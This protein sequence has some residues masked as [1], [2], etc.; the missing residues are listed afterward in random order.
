V[1]ALAVVVAIGVA[2]SAQGVEGHDGSRPARVS[3]SIA[4]GPAG[5]PVARTFI[6]L[7]FEVSSAAQIARYA[8]HGNFARML[9]T[10]GPGLLRL[11]GASADTRV[12]WSD[13]RTPPPAWASSVIGP[14]DLHRLRRLAAETGWRVLLT[15]GL[16]H[17]EPVAAA[18]EA[19]AA[20]R[21]LGSLL[22]GIEVGNEPDSYGHHELRA[23]PWTA[24]VY[25]SEVT[26]YRRAIAHSAPGIP[27]A[28]PGVSG[29][30]AFERWG[31]AEASSQRPALLTGH[32]YPLRCD[33]VP[34][35]SIE[36]L[37]SPRI[38]SLEGVSLARYLQV[39]RA[40][41]TGFRMDEANTVSC[42]GRTGISDTFGSAL[43]AVGY[44]TQSMTAGIS[45]INLQ[46]A[47]ANCT[48][49]SPVCAPT[50]AR[51]AE[52]A[53]QAQPEW[54]A[55]LMTSSLIGDRPLHTRII[56][57]ERPDLATAALRAPDGSLRFVIVEDDPVGTP[58][59]AVRLHVGHGMRAASVLELGA[60]SPA[61]RT[62]IL[63]GGHAVA[64]D[65]S[66]QPPAKLRQIAV[67]GGVVS[68][69]VPASRA[70][71]V[72]VAPRG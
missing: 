9:R 32:H 26:A 15:L 7:S 57:P 36:A 30:K 18:R 68:I 2:L 37:L 50:P 63:L 65:G 62:G 61:A 53:L 17:Y 28:G 12:G 42:G 5:A 33:S 52:G 29:S 70:V 35:P 64:A 54:Y 31:V 45:G 72:T 10:L 51:L 13:S 66:W 58:G 41:H 47:P 55:L 4:P 43:W 25:E 11:G 3:I 21:I 23:P 14:A 34:P 1:A 8:D 56:A 44:I 49:Y 69:E 48:G 20:H 59:A 40:R 16:A 27:L 22:A 60:P 38:R 6:G 39:A 71:L 24:A 19:T 46:G 67:H